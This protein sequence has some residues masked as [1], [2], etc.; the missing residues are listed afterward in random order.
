[1]LRLMFFLVFLVGSVVLGIFLLKHPGYVIIAYH[2]WIM[3]MPLWVALFGSLLFLSIVYLIMTSIDWV[4]FL[5]YRIKNWFRFRREQRFYSKTQQGLSFLIEG[6]WKKAEK[7]LNAGMNQ[8]LE[9]LI[10]YLGAARAADELE[11]YERRDRYLRQAYKMAPSASLAIGLTQASLEIKQGQLEHAA[12]TLNQLR[13]SSP[14]H[15]RVLE[16]LEKVYVRLGDWTHL[17]AI[18]PSM[19]KAKVLTPDQFT[20]FEKN[21]YIELLRHTPP[22]LD[23]MHQ[24]WS[25][26]PRHVKK[27]PDVAAEYVTQLLRVGGATDEAEELIRKTL[28]A[29]WQPTL[30]RIYGTLP[31]AN[32]NRQLV[33]CGAW[34]KAYGPKPEILLTLGRLCMRIR[35]WGRAKEYFERCLAVGPNAEASLEY[36]RL[37]EQLG[38][39]DEARLKYR[40]GLRSLEKYTNHT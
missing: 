36:G 28:K 13:Q 6:R 2:P 34:L 23:D 9:P 18:L 19:R 16:L 20:H 22:R 32:L 40:D 7:F 5:W 24:T 35:L 31:F 14:R 1:M 8:S 12:A 38:E 25:D 15:P 10:N 27:H 39:M 4:Q 21:I 33:I 3:Q 11:A 17:Q 26:I 37:L 30:A 29:N